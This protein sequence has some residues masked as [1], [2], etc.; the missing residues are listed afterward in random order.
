MAVSV[1]MAVAGTLAALVLRTSTYFK[2][3]SDTIEP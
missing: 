1:S 3:R 2:V